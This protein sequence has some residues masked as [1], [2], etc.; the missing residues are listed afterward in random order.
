M[1]QVCCNYA[2]KDGNTQNF[3]KGIKLNNKGKTHLATTAEM[4]KAYAI[5]KQNELAVI[6]VQAHA[7][8]FIAR[9]QYNKKN[10]P[11]ASELEQKIEKMSARHKDKFPGAAGK[12]DRQGDSSR[13]NGLVYARQLAEMPDYSNDLTKETE[14]QL[15]VFEYD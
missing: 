1:G 7:R 3:D 2:P 4:N 13:Q 9:K 8:G 5:G 14:K 10:K 6:K 12:F 11:E 15:G